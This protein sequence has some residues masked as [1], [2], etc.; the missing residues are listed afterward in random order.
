MCLC[1]YIT[2]NICILFIYI[3]LHICRIISA[4]GTNKDMNQS[5]SKKKIE[6][7]YAS[8]KLV[9]KKKKNETEM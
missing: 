4:S 9:K 7:N 8:I 6:I 1:I 2:K 3:W 5:S